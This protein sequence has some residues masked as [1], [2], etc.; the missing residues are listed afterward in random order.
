MAKQYVLTLTA[1]NRV[2]ILAAVANAISELGGDL[3][4]A[5][6]AV[7]QKFFSLILVAEFPDHREPHVIVDHIRD[8][9]RPYGIEVCLK[10]PEE[11]IL[12]SDPQH[13]PEWQIAT[14]TGMDAPGAL[15]RITARLA[16]DG[17]D[18]IHLH[19]L[20]NDDNCSFSM[21]MKLTIPQG[22]DVLQLQREL[23]EHNR[24]LDLS[25]E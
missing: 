6:Q 23:E 11:E 17:I 12:Q 19:A 20:R 18:I 22:V 14:M 7:V 4:E 8:I 16:Q 2:G 15:R 13:R 9:G 5:R 3:H 24:D 10:N 25:V 1:A 21:R